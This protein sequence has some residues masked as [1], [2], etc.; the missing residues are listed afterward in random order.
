MRYTRVL[1]K[2]VGLSLISTVILMLPY[3][4]RD[5]NEEI[6][7]TH[8][9]PASVISSHPSRL[10]FDNSKCFIDATMLKPSSVMRDMLRSKQYSDLV[11]C[12]ARRSVSVKALLPP[13]YLRVRGLIKKLTV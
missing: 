4:F 13:K 12:N 11:A 2:L 10:S 3:K 6:F 1:D 5:V 7:P 9:I 8:T